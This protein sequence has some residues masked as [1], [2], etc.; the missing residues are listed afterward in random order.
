MGGFVNQAIR[1]GLIADVRISI[2]HMES[3]RTPVS[4]WPVPLMIAQRSVSI[5]KDM[6]SPC[7]SRELLAD[8]EK[9]LEVLIEKRESK[10]AL[11]ARLPRPVS[12]FW[13]C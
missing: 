12:G 7:V 6:N 9:R 13:I 4:Q 8:L 1:R 11:E 10:K 2:E 3:G 5:E